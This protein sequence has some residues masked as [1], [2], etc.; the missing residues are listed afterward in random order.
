[1]TREMI[2][3]VGASTSTISNPRDL[4]K[5]DE[6]FSLTVGGYNYP[7]GLASLGKEISKWIEEHKDLEEIEM[8]GKEKGKKLTE[9]L[10]AHPINTPSTP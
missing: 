5:V 10:E 6:V 1:M 3:P 9:Y 7:G 2:T 8:S 4:N